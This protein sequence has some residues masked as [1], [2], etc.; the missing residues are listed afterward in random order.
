[1]NIDDP[2]ING[3]I[4]IRG[5]TRKGVKGLLRRGRKKKGEEEGK[6]GFTLACAGL[7]FVRAD[8]GQG[9]GNVRG[10]DGRLPL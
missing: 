4:S 3:N 7:R 9:R 1:M 6:A 8:V 2:N 10:P 5:I